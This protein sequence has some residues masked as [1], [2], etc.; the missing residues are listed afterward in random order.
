M[1]LLCAA[2]GDP[3]TRFPSLHVVGTNGKSSVTAM[4]AALLSETGLRAGSCLSPHVLRWSERTRIDGVEIAGAA[5]GDA[6]EEVAAAITDVEAD[7]G[8]DERI[9]QFEAAIAASFVALARAEVDVAVIEAGLGGRL[10]ATNVIPSRA[11]ALT[12]VGLDHV[13][14]LGRTRLAIAGE[15]LAVLRE[16]TTLVVGRLEPEVADLARRTATGRGAK[17]ITPDPL[18]PDLLP[19]A[20]APY[21]ARNA[22][23]AVGLAEVFAGEIGPAQ[24]RR[25]L[26]GARLPGRA[27][28]LGG[29]P[30]LLADAAHNEEGAR[31]LTEA[32]PAL[33]RGRPVIACVSILA[34]KDAPAIVRALAPA[35]EVAVCTAA[36]PGPA[37]GRPG[38]RAAEPSDLVELFEAAGVQAS[39]ISDPE[40]AVAETLERARS[41]SGVAL[42]AGSHYLLR[43]A[44]TAKHAQSCSR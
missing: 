36:E 23:V 16:G 1:E 39:A 32:L 27:Q 42:C 11:T 19:P 26:A 43:Y 12:S 6:V 25:G 15:K 18:D 5:F 22:A 3:Q 21:L 24:V 20:M 35:L 33:A 44:W 41:A 34:D 8:E 9:T 4:S 31:A 37:M 17:L 13:E 14:W 28:L 40:R 7:L 30:P 29:E 2:L 38:A 10:D